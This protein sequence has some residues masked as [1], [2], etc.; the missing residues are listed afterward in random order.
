[1]QWKENR[2]NG[3]YN[4]EVDHKSKVQN[5]QNK[6]NKV[7]KS[8]TD[9]FVEIT[10]KAAAAFSRSRSDFPVPRRKIKFGVC[11]FFTPT[12]YRDKDFGYSRISAHSRLGWAGK[13]KEEM[14]V[15]VRSSRSAEEEGDGEKRVRQ[16]A[17]SPPFSPE[18][19]AGRFLFWGIRSVQA[20]EACWP[21]AGLRPESRAGEQTGINMAPD[22]VLP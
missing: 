4:Y 21:L 22:G 6:T 20:A 15:L 19:R 7:K 11:F 3:R 13:T 18:K 9:V 16:T 17:L 12:G 14:K 10:I 2:E 5:K 8:Y 1:M